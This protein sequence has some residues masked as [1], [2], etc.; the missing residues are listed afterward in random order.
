MAKVKQVKGRKSGKVP[1]A[2]MN[3]AG[4][5]EIMAERNG[6]QRSFSVHVWDLLPPD[7]EGWKQVS[8]TPAELPTG[9]GETGTEQTSPE[10]ETESEIETGEEDKG[11]QFEV[12]VTQEYLDLNPEEAAKGTKVGD[13]IFVKGE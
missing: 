7:K 1:E 12:L 4:S 2:S 3:T 5:K 13:T 8:G 6:S 10:K 9:T 11:E